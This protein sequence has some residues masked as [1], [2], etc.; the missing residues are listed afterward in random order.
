MTDHDPRIDPQE[1]DSVVF[2]RCPA[3][4]GCGKKPP[5]PWGNEWERVCGKCNGKGWCRKNKAE[6]VRD[7]K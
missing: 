2:E 1:D 5:Y 7:E 3:C 4:G 6:V